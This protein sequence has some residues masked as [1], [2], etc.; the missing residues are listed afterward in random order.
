M[1]SKNNP[2]AQTLRD[3]IS[4]DEY[5]DNILP[6]YQFCE[7]SFGSQVGDDLKL[8]NIYEAYQK[9]E[10]EIEKMKNEEE[11]LLISSFQLSNSQDGSKIKANLTSNDALNPSYSGASINNSVLNNCISIAEV[12]TLQSGMF[13]NAFYYSKTINMV[14]YKNSTF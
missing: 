3:I 13:L 4:I 5:C 8:S 12:D 6:L 9:F 2:P 10:S 11:E 7:K 14:D 1:C